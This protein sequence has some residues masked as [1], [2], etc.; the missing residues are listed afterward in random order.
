MSA[1]LNA[2]TARRS[3]FFDN[4][5][6][7]LLSRYH[8]FP[9]VKHLRRL[10]G[11]I[12]LIK[13]DLQRIFLPR[14]HKGSP[15]HLVAIVDAGQGEEADSPLKTGDHQCVCVAMDIFR[16]GVGIWFEWSRYSLINGVHFLYGPLEYI[17]LLTEYIFKEQF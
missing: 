4:Y 11:V 12:K 13:A 8:A 16:Y 2:V 17:Y 10:A 3:A 5:E 6:I 15:I 7:S 14:F 9:R 1:E